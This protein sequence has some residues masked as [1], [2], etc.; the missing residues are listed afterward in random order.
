MDPVERVAL[1]ALRAG[2]CFGEICEAMAV[3]EPAEAPAAAAA[4]LARW[5]EDGLIAGIG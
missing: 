1:A 4:L 3:L 5:I 2:R